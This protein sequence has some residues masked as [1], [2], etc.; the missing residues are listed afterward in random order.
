[1]IFID[2][3]AFI[4]LSLKDDAFHQ[5][6]LHW[7]E[8]N[9]KLG[10][11]TTSNLV[12]LETLGWLRYQLG[13]KAAVET[14]KHLLYSPELQR[15]RVSFKDEKL[16]WD[17]FQKSPVRGLSMVDATTVVLCKRLGIKQVFGFDQDFTKYSIQLV[18]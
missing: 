5:Q 6:A 10:N 18:P 11:F 9:F 4:A 12:I 2:T 17:L 15:E 3:S 16:G 13:A 14:G 1:M 8:E 7:W